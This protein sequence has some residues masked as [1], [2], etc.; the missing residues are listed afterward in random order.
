MPRPRRRRRRDPHPRAGRTRSR[1]SSA[2]SAACAGAGVWTRGPRRRRSATRRPTPSRARRTSRLRSA[3]SV[4][5]RGRGGERPADAPADPLG[6]EPPVGRRTGQ[7]LPGG[8]LLD[9]ELS[10][11]S[12]IAA[13]NRALDSGSTNSP[14]RVNSSER[15]CLPQGVPASSAWV[16]GG[17]S[18]TL[19]DQA[20]SLAR[21][22]KRPLV[23]AQ[24]WDHP[25]SMAGL[26]S[27]PTPTP[28]ASRRSSAAWRRLGRRFGD[29]GRDRPGVRRRR[30]ADPVGV[31]RAPRR[32]KAS[33]S[34]CAVPSTARGHRHPADR[35]PAA[36]GRAQ[37]GPVPAGGQRQPAPA[38]SRSPRSSPASSASAPSRS[39]CTRCTAGSAPTTARCTRPTRCCRTRRAGG[40][41]LRHQHLP[42]LDQRATATRCCSTRCCATSRAARRARARRPGLVVRRRRLP[43]AVR[44][45]T[46][47]S[48][49][50][51]CRRSGCP[52]TT[53][54]FDL[55]P[56]G[57]RLIFG[58]D[59]PGVPASP[60]RPRGRRAVSG[61]GDRR[62]RPRRQRARVYGLDVPE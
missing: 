37:P 21:L 9:A 31:R 8:L 52:T 59:W 19:H 35:G 45:P 41:A 23:N 3:P 17:H 46:S 33:T 16:G 27:T 48:S 30:H 36:A 28:P 14:S 51:G 34:R 53:R 2:S 10:R 47:G 11:T 18:A 57:P 24:R 39:S 40:R 7:G 56:A 42:G 20:A 13:V 4:S 58:T 22:W 26:L 6:G 44:A 60:Q 29:G 32:P 54:G 43:R 49:C 55:R 62:A 1:P 15:A 5:S 12:T 50:P 38:L 25:C 61:R